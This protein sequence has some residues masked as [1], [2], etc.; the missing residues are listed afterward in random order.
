MQKIRGGGVNFNQ[1]PNGKS[2]QYWQ[3]TNI[4]N[5][6]REI[7]YKCNCIAFQYEFKLSVFENKNI[8]FC[9]ISWKKFHFG[10][11]NYYRLRRKDELTQ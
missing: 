1:V 9:K 6:Q 10:A 7:D 3:C 2:A 8:I 4:V 5:M 11:Q